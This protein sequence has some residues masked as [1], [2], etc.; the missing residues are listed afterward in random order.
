MRAHQP[1]GA[2]VCAA[3]PRCVGRAACQLKGGGTGDSGGRAKSECCEEALFPER[4][5]QTDGGKRPA[6]EAV[7]RNSFQSHQ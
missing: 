3:P 6:V 2:S 1:P 4:K 5:E 7:H